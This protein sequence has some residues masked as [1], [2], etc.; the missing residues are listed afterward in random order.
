MESQALKHMESEENERSNFKGKVMGSEAAKTADSEDHECSGT[1]RKVMESQAVK[2]TG[3]E[4]NERN[5]ITGEA[6]VKEAPK[7]IGSEESEF[8][9]SID[10][11]MESKIV[12]ST[13]SS[14]ICSILSATP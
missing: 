12:G 13:G 11:V 8:S 3:G 4:E 14:R 10:K 7:H 1:I 2:H 5:R 9:R 6:T